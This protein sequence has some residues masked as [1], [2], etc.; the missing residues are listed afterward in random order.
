[1]CSW[2]EQIIKFWLKNNPNV[3]VLYL[4]SRLPFASVAAD[5]NA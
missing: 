2:V 3:D 5:Y 1:M 4:V